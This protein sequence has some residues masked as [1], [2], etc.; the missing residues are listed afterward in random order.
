V[1]AAI[2]AA[3][4]FA[5]A[6]ASALGGAESVAFF[7]TPSAN[8][9]CI[10]ASGEPGFPATLRCD[11]R[12]GLRPRPAQPRGCDL[13][14][15][16]SFELHKTGRPFVVCHGDTVFDP[17]ARVLAYGT[18]WVRDGFRCT[19]RP[20]GLRCTNPSGHGFFLSR[21]RSFAF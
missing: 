2:L 1:R 3:L 8:I 21:E 18:A 13:D 11:I 7:R 4:A 15:G 17:R 5:L 14:Y 16:D 9:G 12:S 20:T 10:Y 19:S 6:P